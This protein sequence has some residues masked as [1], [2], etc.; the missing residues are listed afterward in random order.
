MP[1]P[2]LF[3]ATARAMAMNHYSP[4]FAIVVIGGDVLAEPASEMNLG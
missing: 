2:V 3:A 1:N 4:V